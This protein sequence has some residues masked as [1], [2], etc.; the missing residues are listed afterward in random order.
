MPRKAK[1]EPEGEKRGRG[2][3]TKYLPEY[4][5]RVIAWGKEGK[6]IAQMAAEIGVSYNSLL[7][8]WPKQNPEFKEAMELWEVHAQAFWEAKIPDNLTNREFQAHLYLRSMAARFPKHWR[9]STRS[10]LTGPNGEPL[11]P[12][13]MLPD[14][15]HLTDDQL[16]MLA[17]IRL[18]RD[19]EEE[20]V[21]H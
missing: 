21:R 17:T 8:N 15:S 9:E 6:S 10:E 13:A 16:A 1:A 3:P 14:V 12:P 11:N 7:V 18:K 4:C 19:D 2:Q 20:P 5:E